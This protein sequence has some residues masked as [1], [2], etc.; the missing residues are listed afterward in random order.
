LIKQDFD[1][2]FKSCDIILTPTT[3]T[4]AFK[5]GEK[6]QDPLQMYLSDIFTIPANLAGIPAVSVPCGYTKDNLP[7]GM[8]FMAKHFDEPTLLRAAY[9]Y[10]KN[11]RWQKRK[12][13]L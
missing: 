5:L 11:A 3:P 1:N 10:E 4:T 7:M 2:A 13:N 6:I 8:Q 9:T 12:P